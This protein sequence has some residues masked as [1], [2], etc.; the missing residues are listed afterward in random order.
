[1]HM[2]LSV[3]SSFSFKENNK[4]GWN[5]EWKQVKIGKILVKIGDF[6]IFYHF[7]IT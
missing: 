5:F 4:Q 1:M 6:T 3:I 7:Q 2:D